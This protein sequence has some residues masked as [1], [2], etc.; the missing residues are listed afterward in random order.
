MRSPDKSFNSRNGLYVVVAI[1]T[2]VI[3]PTIKVTILIYNKTPFGRRLISFD[4]YRCAKKS[5]F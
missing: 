3:V 4:K 5:F 1:P 2:E